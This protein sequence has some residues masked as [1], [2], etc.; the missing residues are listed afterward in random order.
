MSTD[1]SEPVDIGLFQCNFDRI[2]DV[3]MYIQFQ[4]LM[5]LQEIVITQ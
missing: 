1:N 2:I 4:V 3:M 5:S